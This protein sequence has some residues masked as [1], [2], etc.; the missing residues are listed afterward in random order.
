MGN[1]LEILED[2]LSHVATCAQRVEEVGTRTS[3]R[4]LRIQDVSSKMLSAI[5]DLTS[6]VAKIADTLDSIGEPLAKVA[7]TKECEKCDKFEA[8]LKRMRAELETSRRRL[9]ELEKNKVDPLKFLNLLKD[10]EKRGNV[11]IDLKTGDVEVL[12]EIPFVARKSN[13]EPIAEFSDSDVAKSIIRDIKDV[14]SVVP[15]EM[16]VEGHTKGGETAFWQSLADNRATLIVSILRDL[17]VD[18]K[19]VKSK[20]LPGRRGKNKVGVVVKLDI[21]PDD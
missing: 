17:G 18:P 15:V 7:E 8:E 10:V 9:T 5:I 1:S 3:D 13:E 11:S 2:K 12:R 16:C 4:A 14:W 21:F 6:K 19:F 20:G